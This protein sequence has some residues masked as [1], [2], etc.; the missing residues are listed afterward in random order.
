MTEE[1]FER[2]KES[3]DEFLEDV[4]YS[5]DQK[6]DEFLE[7]TGKTRD[8]DFCVGVRCD[9]VFFRATFCIFKQKRVEKL[10]ETPREEW[11][12]LIEKSNKERLRLLLG[13]LKS[14]DE[15]YDKE[16]KKL[17]SSSR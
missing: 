10:K 6:L 12:S 3:D 13:E 1:F 4:D 2:L 16:S 17:S 9:K 8:D 7:K 14:L 11:D 5:Y 15:F